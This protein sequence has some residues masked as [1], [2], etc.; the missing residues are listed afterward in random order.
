MSWYMCTIVVKY[1]GILTTIVCLHAVICAS[2]SIGDEWSRS[3]WRE[4]FLIR[5]MLWH[6]LRSFWKWFKW[7][8]TV[9]MTSDIPFMALNPFHQD[10]CQLNHAKNI[11]TYPNKLQDISPSKTIRSYYNYSKNSSSN[12]HAPWPRHQTS[13]I[14]QPNNIH[15]LHFLQSHSHLIFLDDWYSYVNV[16]VL[17]WTICCI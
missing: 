17:I 11:Q 16:T 3:F 7:C 15:S 1:N 12:S 2:F 4:V 5:S 8:T 14:T 10:N 6:F 9:R 13:N